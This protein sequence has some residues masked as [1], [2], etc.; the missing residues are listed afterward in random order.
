MK[1]TAAIEA[2]AS[3]AAL[4]ARRDQWAKVQIRATCAVLAMLAVTVC[5][6]VLA[7]NLGPQHVISDIQ[8][9]DALAKAIAALSSSHGNAYGRLAP[10]YEQLSSWA[11]G[12]LAKVVGF[13]GLFMGLAVGVIKQSIGAAV[14]GITMAVAT[15]MM[16]AM[17]DDMAGG[18]T[19]V[20]RGRSEA[21]VA[22]IA[23]ERRDTEV[24]REVLGRVEGS[25]ALEGDF[26]L[27]QMNAGNASSAIAPD[28]EIGLGKE[29]QPARSDASNVLTK[30]AG[31][32][33]ILPRP[34]VLYALETSAFGA[35]RSDSAKAYLTEREGRAQMARTAAWLLGSL[36]GLATTALGA[37][38]LVS[39]LISRRIRRIN[40]LLAST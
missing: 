17:L 39:V 5:V 6:V 1:S 28:S 2:Q 30:L 31:Q 12:T 9:P 23:I 19:G 33:E 32:K 40:D 4:A 38:F 7:G 16:P 26:V 14:V 36:T 3:V 20:S 11:G 8:V 21:S 25:F 24:F 34:D 18:A 13:C 27:A 37:W 10:A 22:Q 29:N 35:A 15:M